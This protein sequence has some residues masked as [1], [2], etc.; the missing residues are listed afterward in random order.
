ML[1]TFKK[2]I[3]SEVLKNK[4]YNI[5]PLLLYHHINIELTKR[6]NTYI[7]NSFSIKSNTQK[8]N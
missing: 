7:R 6:R 4:S 1:L 2:L 5:Y 8:L 3:K